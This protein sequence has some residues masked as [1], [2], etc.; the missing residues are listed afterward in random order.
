MAF[1]DVDL[2][3]TQAAFVTD[4]SPS[5]NYHGAAK[6]Q[7]AG[8]NASSSYQ[9]NRLLLSFEDLPA[10]Y[11]YRG[12]YSAVFHFTANRNL[13]YY[14]L[15]GFFAY[16]LRESFDEETV[17]WADKPASSGRFS[18]VGG[19]DHGSG[20]YDF[21]IYAYLSDERDDA[22]QA[23]LAALE[24][25]GFYLVTSDRLHGEYYTDIYSKAAAAGKKPFLR[26]SVGDDTPTVKTVL[27]AP[28]LKE[29]FDKS[30]PATFSWDYEFLTRVR[31]FAPIVQSSA[32]LYWRAANTE[33]PWQAVTVSGDVRSYTFP[34]NTLPARDIEW[35]VVPV[36]VGYNSVQS[37]YRWVCP[38][39]FE[40]LQTTGLAT[41]KQTD[42]ETAFPW[43]GS[44]TVSF[45]SF[46]YS[47]PQKVWLLAQF[48][49]LRSGL[50]Y[51]AVDRA[52]IAIR[53]YIPAGESR[54]VDLHFLSGGFNPDTVTWDTMPSSGLDRGGRSYDNQE[55]DRGVILD[56]FFVTAMW[57]E[58]HVAPQ[59]DRD[60]SKLAVDTLLSPGFMLEARNKFPRVS[61]PHYNPFF[62]QDPVFL[63]AHVLDIIVTSTPAATTNASGYVNPHVAQ[64]FSWQ[65]VPDGDYWCVAGWTT[66]SAT[67]YWRQAN[68]ETWNSVAAAANSSE[69]ILPAE[70]LP[71]GSVEW[72]VTATDDQGTTASSEIY[73]ISTADT[74]HTA[75]P[76]Y[77]I[78][79][80]ENGDAGIRFIWTDA[81]DTGA[82]PAGAD[83]QYF[84]DQGATWT[85]F[86]SPRT[87]ATQYDAPGGGFPPGVLLWR[88]RS[89]NAE[90]T[91]GPWSEA[92][93]FLCFAAPDPPII[94]SDG[95][96]FLTVT[97][98]SAGQR[99]YRVTIDG[100]NYG[101]YFGDGKSFQTPEYLS[102]GSHVVRVEIQNEYGLWNGAE[103]AVTVANV[104][105]SPV[106]LSGSFDRDAAL[107]WTCEDATADFLV[108]R[109]DVQIG[110]S[111]GYSFTDRTV[112]DFHT[113]RVIN[114]L[115]GGY[116]TTSNTVSGTLCTEGLALALLAGGPWIDLT[117]STNAIR[118]TTAAA[119]R[120][121]VL[122]QFAGRE[123]PDAEA[124][125]YKTLQI[126][127]DVSW[128]PAQAAQAR[129]FEALIGEAVI[130]K[131]PGE[132][133]VV[134]VLSAFQ[135]S[136]SFP[137]RSYTATVQRIHWREYVDA[138]S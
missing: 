72:Y 116:Y 79:T 11:R 39:V 81:S 8:D 42:P 83:L 115:P 100:K 20:D 25:P 27:T 1:I 122:R 74:L 16:I 123:Y 77:P 71:V 7:L 119:G 64:V 97:W 70:T 107:R 3:C 106:I 75:T 132:E 44:T 6:Y 51:N 43:T 58:S 56:P 10:E 17:T 35:Y 96:P 95:K 63:R 57:F 104:P 128:T 113:W 117:L 135:R 68:A 47:S 114:R 49:S 91:A 5:T 21:L 76:V 137:A 94:D 101:P 92:V 118:T 134:G 85:D 46:T 73:T 110:H 84:D 23:A 36:I 61:S 12:L 32:T 129:A 19:P 78:D 90:G 131:E 65:H 125:P 31:G 103:I 89:L 38:R 130:F 18:D 98:Q 30:Q 33:D 111:S 87:S 105:G 59:N 26:V 80:T 48:H 4:A 22:P 28:T 120:S 102:D 67:L 37:G 109:D 54:G 124:A 15:P 62:I 93:S 69:V 41:V 13:G 66:Q 60:W 121:V 29:R 53:T 88:V 108:Y 24:A 82:A 40:H 52:E 133:A 45:V 126:S 136:H 50:A 127:F 34:A 55:G 112:L 14:N 2:A 9:G 86:A 99:A 138:D